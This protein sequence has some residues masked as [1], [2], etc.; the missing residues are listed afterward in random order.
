[1]VLDVANQP[2]WLALFLLALSPAI[3]EEI[4]MRGIILSNYRSKPVLTTCL[5]NGLFFG[6]FHMNINQ[7][8]YAFA[9]GVVLCFVVHVTGSI[10]SAMV[11]HF[12]INASS[13]ILA[14]ISLYME[15]V[16]TQIY[17]SYT[18]QMSEV[19]ITTETLTMAAISLSIIC[20]IAAPLSYLIMRSLI[21]RNHLENIF[22][23]K[24]TTGEVLNLP[25]QNTVPHEKI[26]TPSLIAAVSIFTIFVVFFEIIIFFLPS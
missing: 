2:L 10:V 17:P 1:M 11:I 8:I 16:L 24:L 20:L 6:L 5:I 23:D 15:E 3:V 25:S 26:N 14:K 22:K 18:Q 9:M 4:S 13:L 21:K 12:T 7:F 19:V